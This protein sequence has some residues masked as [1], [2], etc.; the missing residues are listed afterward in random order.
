MESSKRRFSH[1]GGTV[2]APAALALL[3]LFFPAGGSMISFTPTLVAARKVPPLVP[4]TARPGSI[5]RFLL[6]LPLMMTTMTGVLSNPTGAPFCR[7]EGCAKSNWVGGN[8]DVSLQVDNLSV[9]EGDF[10]VVRVI[11]SAFTTELKGLLLV[12]VD[13]SEDSLRPLGRFVRG[14]DFGHETIDWSYGPCGPNS[15]THVGNNRKKLPLEFV[16][17]VPS[18]FVGPAYFRAVIVRGYDQW[19]TISVGPVT[20]WKQD[21]EG[22]GGASKGTMA[23]ITG[24]AKTKSKPGPFVILLLL[25]LA[26]SRSGSSSGLL[27]LHLL[28]LGLLELRV[29]YNGPNG[30]V[31]GG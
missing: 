5:F 7:I 3:L 18:G 28:L 24:K 25:A 1:P 14:R 29:L 12:S 11:G 20:S 19:T 8:Y 16:W 9:K 21:I 4:S 26:A 22:K 27:F 6:G 15:I 30:V 2:G 31:S 10:V 23:A 13:R 17:E